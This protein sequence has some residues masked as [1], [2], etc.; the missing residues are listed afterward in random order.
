ML[1]QNTARIFSSRMA[2]LST[3][4]LSSLEMTFRARRG[5]E[6][7]DRRGVHDHRYAM[8]YQGMIGRVAWRAIMP[9]HAR[10]G[11]GHPMRQVYARVSKS[12]SRVRRGEHHVSASLVIPWICHGATQIG[13]DRPKCFHA[14]QIADWIQTLIRRAQA[15]PLG[16]DALLK[17]NSS[18]GFD[19]VA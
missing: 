3:Q 13:S 10:D 2:D 16:C 1:G 18:V 4:N 12:N 6:T 14:P 9:N 8:R 5:S 7:E 19:G 15:G 11:V 17:R